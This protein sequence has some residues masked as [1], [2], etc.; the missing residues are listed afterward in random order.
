VEDKTVAHVARLTLNVD[1]TGKSRNLTRPPLDGV[2]RGGIE[3]HDRNVILNR[4]NTAALTTLQ[5]LPIRIQH[6]WL[7]AKRADQHVEEVLRN[8]GGSIV[9]PILNGRY[10]A[11]E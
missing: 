2:N 9:S 10:C 3:Q 8:H 5:A 4:V 11:T 6:H 1:T 7:L